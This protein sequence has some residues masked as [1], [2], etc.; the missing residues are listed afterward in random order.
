MLT[1]SHVVAFAL[2]ATGSSA[3]PA[4]CAFD[5]EALLK[6]D[7]RSFD[8]DT[9]GGWRA[10]A[11]KGCDREAADLI[12][13]W[14]LQH[15]DSRS[16]LFWHEGQSRAFD[17]DYE[18]AASLFEK[19]RKPDE[20]RIG[21]NFYVDGSIAFLRGDMTKLQAARASLAR[22]PKPADWDMMKDDDGKVL[23]IKWPVNLNVLDDFIRCWGRPYRDAYGCQHQTP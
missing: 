14:R 21:W 22:M 13:D 19:S 12:R 17:G 8:Q 6:L 11:S 23:N 15:N 2:S 16:I 3:V 10:L 20:D 4:D 7:Y 1:F 18:A 5:R 9:H